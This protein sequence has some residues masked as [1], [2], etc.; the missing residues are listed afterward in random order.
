MMRPVPFREHLLFVAS[1]V[2]VW[3]FHR[4]RRHCV[5]NATK[6]DRPMPEKPVTACEA[7]L[8]V[9]IAWCALESLK[10]RCAN[11]DTEDLGLFV[12]PVADCIA[13]VEAT[14]KTLRAYVTQ[15]DPEGETALIRKTPAKGLDHHI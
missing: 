2:S 8:M 3:D 9:F 1:E 5:H 11:P 14:L 7:R 12:Q 10:A 15:Q 4:L 6:K 13:D